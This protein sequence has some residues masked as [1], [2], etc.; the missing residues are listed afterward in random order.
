MVMVDLELFP[1]PSVKQELAQDGIAVH[2]SAT[3]TQSQHK[4]NFS[5]TKISVCMFLG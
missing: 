5:I 1:G 2:H 4:G 3:H